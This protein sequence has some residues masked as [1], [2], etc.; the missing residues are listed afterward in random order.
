L[1]GHFDVVMVNQ[2]H[3]SVHSLPEPLQ[4][5]EVAMYT[6]RAKSENTVF[7]L[8]IINRV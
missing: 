1:D 6:G 4:E 2:L 7:R 5:I 8:F 3:K